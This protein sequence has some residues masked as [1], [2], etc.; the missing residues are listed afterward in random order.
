MQ[1]LI[2][3]SEYFDLHCETAKCSTLFTEAVAEAR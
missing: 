3:D 2:Q 1:V